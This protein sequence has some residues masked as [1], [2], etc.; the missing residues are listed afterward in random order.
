M[1]RTDLH[2]DERLALPVA[3]NALLW[4]MRVWVAGLNRDIGAERR[5]E[6]VLALLNAPEAAEYLFGFMFAL[7]HA[8][9]RTIGVECPCRPRVS[10]D[11]RLLLGVFALAQKGQSLDAMLALRG[12]VSAPG[13][14]VAWLSAEGVAGALL[15]TGRRLAPPASTTARYAVFRRPEPAGRTL[16]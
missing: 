4:C 5:I 14:R 15:R 2:Y 7:R 8:A 3:E 11:E 12:L 13:A 6:D 10:A 1:M 9:V 16:H